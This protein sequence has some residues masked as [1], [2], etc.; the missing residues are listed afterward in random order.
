MLIFHLL[1]SSVATPLQAESA[2][3]QAII[4]DFRTGETT[5]LPIVPGPNIPGQGFPGTAPVRFDGIVD[6]GGRTW[7]SDLT[8]VTNSTTFPFSAVCT[9]RGLT[10]GGAKIAYGSGSLVDPLHVITAGHVVWRKGAGIPMSPQFGIAAGLDTTTNQTEILLKSDR[11]IKFGTAQ[12]VRMLVMPDW[13]S[14]AWNGYDADMALLELDRPVGHLTGTLGMSVEGDGFFPQ[15]L[16]HMAGYPVEGMSTGNAYPGAPN[17]MYVG[18]GVH[19][20]VWEEQVF[21]A[22]DWSHPSKGTSGGPLY[23]GGP[24]PSDFTVLGVHSHWFWFFGEYTADCRL[25]SWKLQAI[26][27]FM[28]GGVYNQTEPDWTPLGVEAWPWMHPGWNYDLSFVLANNSDVD[29]GPTD[30]DIEFFLEKGTSAISLGITTINVDFAPREGR[31]I[32]FPG[33]DIPASVGPG[34]YS[35]TVEVRAAADSNPNNNMVAKVTSD[36]QKV[37]VMTIDSTILYVF[38][39][40]VQRGVIVTFEIWNAPANRAIF[41]AG[42]QTIGGYMWHGNHFVDLAPPYEF[43]LPGQTDS[44]GHALMTFTVPVNLPPSFSSLNWETMCQGSN[45]LWYDSNL[46]YLMIT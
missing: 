37:D 36:C 21:G 4:Y 28:A 27:S 45:G 26:E 46:V 40:V 24:N 23:K 31:E 10:N 35:L 38:P 16:V 25:T 17:Q 32:S 2:Y 30:L 8:A 6:N 11:T 9:I 5:Y 29:P 18:D 43:M 22:R 41:L 34:S 19:D 44:H 12:V 20:H 15:N 33:T 42:G 1:L 13:Q 14:G 39:G 3:P 7:N